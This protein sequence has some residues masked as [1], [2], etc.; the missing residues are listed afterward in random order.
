MGAVE[1]CRP[2]ARVGLLLATVCLSVPSWPAWA[3]DVYA[4]P[5]RGQSSAQQNQDRYECHSWA[6]SQTGFDPTRQSVQQAPAAGAPPP[7]GDVLRGAG[8]GAAIGAVGG[9][10]GGDAGKG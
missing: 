6:V 4:Y 1:L 10:I 7:Q 3:Q 2:R 5:T 8:R 9:A